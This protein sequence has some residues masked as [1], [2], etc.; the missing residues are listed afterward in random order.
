MNMEQDKD[1]YTVAKRT[2]S[3]TPSGWFGDSKDMIVELENFMTQ[4][5]IDEILSV[6]NDFG[7]DLSEFDD[8]TWVDDSIYD[9]DD[10]SDLG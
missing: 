4:E 5:E 8:D 10:G 9:D 3:M 1:S 7:I 2:P 6:E